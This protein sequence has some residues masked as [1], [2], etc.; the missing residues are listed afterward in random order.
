M[1]RY[2]YILISLLLFVACGNSKKEKT[3]AGQE[4]GTE[5]TKSADIIYPKDTTAI[6]VDLDGGEGKVS[7]HKQERQS[8]YLAFDADGYKKLKAVITPREQTGNIRFNQI[9]LPDGSMDGPFGRTIEYDLPD[10]GAYKLILGESLMAGDPWSGDFD[11][12]IQLHN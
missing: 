6:L 12:S 10:N 3:T 5:K 4:A 11:V 8:V 7:V 9:V 2:I 1:N